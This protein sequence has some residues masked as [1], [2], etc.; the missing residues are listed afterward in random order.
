MADLFG[1]QL[2]RG[3]RYNYRGKVFHR[4]TPYEV[5]R[6]TRDYLVL[7]TKAFRDVSITGPVEPEPI[8]VARGKVSNLRDQA[9]LSDRIDNPALGPMASDGP[10]IRAAG[11]EPTDEIE[12]PTGITPPPGKM[13]VKQNGIESDYEEAAPRRGRTAQGGTVAARTARRKV[14]EDSAVFEASRAE[15]AARMP[16]QAQIDAIPPSER[17]DVEHVDDGSGV[18]V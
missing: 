16:T 11:P 1:I 7:S 8:P 9:Q 15:R 10:V 18:E 14:G 4:G 12:A 5:D 13:V 3:N 17:F 2:V 6:A